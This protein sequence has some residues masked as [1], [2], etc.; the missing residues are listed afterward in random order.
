[1]LLLQARDRP[2]SADVV[3][4]H[5]FAADAGV[6]CGIAEDLS[7]S[8]EDGAVD[9]D[10][11]GAL[12]CGEGQ[13]CCLLDEGVHNASWA[14]RIGGSPEIRGESDPGD[15]RQRLKRVARR[16]APDHDKIEST[17]IEQRATLLSIH[18]NA[19]I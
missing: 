4:L 13:L 12:V 16:N 1:M 14:H 17:K 15:R 10:A 9:L 8:F 11:G 18:E 6:G 3:D 5:G 7:A 2:L 19:S